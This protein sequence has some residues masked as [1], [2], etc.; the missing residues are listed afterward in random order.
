M[1]GRGSG[2]RREEEGSCPYLDLHLDLQ[3]G[4][5]DGEQR[6]V[7]AGGAQLPGTV[8]H[9]PVGVSQED[10]RGEGGDL[11]GEGAL[12]CRGGHRGLHFICTPTHIS[13]PHFVSGVCSWFT[14]STH[15]HTHLTPTLTPPTPL[16]P[17]TLTLTSPTPTLTP[18]THVHVHPQYTVGGPVL[19]QLVPTSHF[20][21]RVEQEVVRKPEDNQW[22]TATHTA[23]NGFIHIHCTIQHICT[24]KML[25]SLDCLSHMY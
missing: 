14:H 16:T 20:G 19:V 7:R 12:V 22:T 18:P 10:Q 21:L 3:V 23:N 24:N 15:P 11:A 9:V 25:C 1:A 6:A 8:G 2:G 4:P 17:P 5:V 13:L